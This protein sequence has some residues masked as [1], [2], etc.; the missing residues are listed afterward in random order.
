MKNLNNNLR[1]MGSNGYQF[2]NISSKVSTVQSDK[3]SSN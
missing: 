2:K 1:D 3:I